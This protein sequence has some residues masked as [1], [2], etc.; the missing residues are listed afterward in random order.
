MFTFAVATD[1]APTSD[2]D[3]TGVRSSSTSTLDFRCDFDLGVFS[4]ATSEELP[5]DVQAD[6]GINPVSEESRVFFSSRGVRISDGLILVNVRVGRAEAFSGSG[7][8]R[9]MPSEVL[10]KAELVG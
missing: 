1:S 8:A 10:R 3:S 4:G 9:K 5:T 6:M 2:R 7:P